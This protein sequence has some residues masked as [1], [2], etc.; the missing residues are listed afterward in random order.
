MLSELSKV[1]APSE[2]AVDP[3]GM[4]R[5]PWGALSLLTTSAHGIPAHFA[6]IEVGPSLFPVQIL[7]GIKTGGA[8]LDDVVLD[9]DGV[10][11]AY[12]YSFARPVFALRAQRT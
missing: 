4:V 1:T 10:A 8:A 11:K 12:R 7:K 2:A 9:R 6:F 5:V 3:T